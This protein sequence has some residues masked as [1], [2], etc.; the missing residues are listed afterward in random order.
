MKKKSSCQKLILSL[1]VA[2]QKA[3]SITH[4]FLYNDIFNS[5][6]YFFLHFLQGKQFMIYSYIKNEE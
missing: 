3:I 1:P 4:L 5:I 2:H 6:L